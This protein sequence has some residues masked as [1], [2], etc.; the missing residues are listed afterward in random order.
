MYECVL[1]NRHFGDL[2]PITFGEEAC[3][4][5]HSYGP[6]AR[7]YT[8]VHFVSGGRG[9]F[10]CNGIDYPVS[11]GEAF[12]ICPDDIITYTADGDDP[13]DYAWI[14]FDGVLSARF[15]SLPAVIPYT[16]DWAREIAQLERDPG[17]LEYHIASK[18]FLMYS[19]W[20]SDKKEK[21]DYVRTI[22]DYINAK[23]MQNI[24][25]EEIASHMNLDRR[26]LSRVFK[27][28]TGMS[29]QEYIIRVRIEKSKK[30]LRQ[31]YSVV[32]T[33]RFCGYDDACNFSKIFKKQ[34]GISPGHWK[35]ERKAE[36][37]DI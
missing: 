4:P 19:E 21:P 30:F 18:L 15:R 25:V 3:A 22:K 26:Y 7:E 31:G 32:E 24:H 6:G 2:N 17:T 20:F 9:I 28:K 16:T 27:Q 33:A 1:S 10:R 35:T 34:T 11:A 23:F 13:W 29:I 12:I 8:L 36:N 37:G 14:G 5:G